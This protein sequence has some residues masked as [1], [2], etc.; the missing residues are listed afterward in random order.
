M[1]VFTSTFTVISSR[2]TTSLVSPLTVAGA[3]TVKPR[4]CNR[5]DM[6]LISAVIRA[7]AASRGTV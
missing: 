7:S 3:E 1:T 4:V 6:A 2:R 5:S